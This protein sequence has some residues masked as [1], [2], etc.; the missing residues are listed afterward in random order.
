KKRERESSHV[1]GEKEKLSKDVNA[2]VVVTDS[3]IGKTAR[4]GGGWRVVRPFFC[5]I[6][7]FFFGK[8]R[9]EKINLSFLYPQVC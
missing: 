8:C 9:Y 5:L 1:D 7:D 3:K 2:L 6:I 4:S